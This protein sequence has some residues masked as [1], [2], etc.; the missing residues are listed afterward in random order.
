MTTFS[1]VLPFAEH[2]AQVRESLLALARCKNLSRFEILLVWNSRR[3]LS[4]DS[5]AEIR[6]CLGSAPIRILQYAERQGASQAWCFG[7][8][9]AEMEYVCLL[10]I[11]APVAPDW[12]T[13]VLAAI[14]GT[15]DIYQGDYSAS[16]VDDVCGRLESAIDRVRFGDLGI[17]DFRNAVIR[18]TA[19]LSIL[20]DHFSGLF[21]TDIELDALQPYLRN[22]SV[23]RMPQARV[24][25]AYPRSVFRCARR[26]FRHGVA[27]GRIRRCFP[28]PA[29][30]ARSS[31]AAPVRTRGSEAIRSSV[32]LFSRTLALTDGLAAKLA[33][34]AMHVI[35]FSGAALG[36]LLPG[37]FART[38]YTMH[39]DE[40]A[41]CPRN[42]GG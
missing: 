34:S 39:F 30:R 22:L 40:Q 27:V 19:A 23:R 20:D 11:D 7:L 26:K 9:Q 8:R 33:L 3:P 14:D 4:A 24:V 42:P 16:A 1:V 2:T 37:A 25:N 31:R 5:E 10:A 12:D 32:R 38:F 15:A 21:F 36:R 6:S 28:G 29:V 41:G 13:T 35:F 18:R 17:V